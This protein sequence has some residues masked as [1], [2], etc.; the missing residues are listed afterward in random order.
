MRELT[1]LLAAALSESSFGAGTHGMLNADQMRQV[2]SRGDLGS[3]LVYSVSLVV[4]QAHLETLVNAL[5]AELGAFIEPDTQRLGTG[6]VSLMGGALEYAEPTV[7][8]FARTLVRAGLILGPQ[9]TVEIL[10]GWV[11]DEPYRYRRMMLLTGVQCEEPLSLEEGVRIMQLPTNPAEVLACLPR[12]MTMTGI[13]ATK[14]TGRALVAIDSTATPALYRPTRSD[15]Q[16]PGRNLE[17][18]R[19]GGRLPGLTTDMWRK[20]FTDALSLACDHHVRWTHIWH[21][22]G[23]IWAFDRSGSSSYESS[24]SHSPGRELLHLEQQH[25]ETARDIDAQR[26]ANA[27]GRKSLDIAIGRWISSKRPYASLADRFIDLR[28]ALEALYLPHSGPEMQFRLAFFGAWD[29]G[30]DFQQRRYYY[31]LFRKAYN[32]GSKAV[33]DG[34]VEDEAENREKL[35]S[36]Q[37]A[38]RQAILKCLAACEEH[39]WEKIDKALGA[40]AG[41]P[42][43]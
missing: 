25:L 34:H 30:T 14:F 31:D 20:R 41:N 23:D 4:P 1:D 32:L 2:H 16:Q 21:D 38:C 29:L 26:H 17:H 42:P 11:N 13:D 8:E 15:D 28:I 3:F 22:F 39:A 43:L 5:H 36:A 40:A 35:A 7:D 18:V 27:S 6:L 37:D 24:P 19:A 9:R 33:H 12:S 10:R